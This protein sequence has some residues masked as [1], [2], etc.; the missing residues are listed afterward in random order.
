M[1]KGRGHEVMWEA[2]FLSL[3]RTDLGARGFRS[4]QEEEGFVMDPFSGNDTNH[5]MVFI[6]AIYPPKN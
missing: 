6:S 4:L 5:F 3:P 2:H 1:R